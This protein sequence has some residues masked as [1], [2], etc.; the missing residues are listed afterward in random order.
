MNS[1]DQALCDALAA[2]LDGSV[3]RLVRNWQDRLYRFA[4]RLSGS[5]ADAEEIAQDAFVRCY[6]ALQD[7]D[8]ARIR[9]LA[10]RPW[11]YRI[12]L[13]VARNRARRRVPA[14]EEI[15]E[16]P[17]GA[18]DPG[19]LALRA[20]RLG[21]LQ[22]ALTALPETPRAAVVLRYVEGLSYAEIGTVLHIPEGT[23]RSHVHR[24]L[25]TL[26]TMMDEEETA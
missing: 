14:P 13:N 8:A 26:R 16:R 17:D 20:E 21:E 10:L 15:G 12:A 23:A 18:P 1:D 22:R 19:M 24:A 2:D 11:L 3:E 4:L 6:R 5:P 25:R 7:Y 9:A